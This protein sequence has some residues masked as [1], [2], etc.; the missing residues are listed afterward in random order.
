M[1]KAPR[2]I[3]KTIRKL[4]AARNELQNVFPD[5]SFTL[6]GNL[7]GDIGEAIAIAEFGFKKLKCGNKT[8]DVETP[9][10]TFVQIKTTQKTKGGVGLGL[11]KQSFEHLIVL[12]LHEQGTYSVLYDGPGSYVEAATKHKKSAGLSVRQLS[13]LDDTI[14][15]RE[16]LLKPQ[17]RAPI[18]QSP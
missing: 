14:P 12:Q 4:Y 1:N 16:R 11:T 5:L 6:D 7:I 9:N 17:L 2:N 15:R 8:H 3:G 18:R 10:G 13:E